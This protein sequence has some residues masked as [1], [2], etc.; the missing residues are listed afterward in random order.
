MPST[1]EEAAH[2]LHSAEVTMSVPEH[3]PRCIPFLTE[4]DL[5][6]RMVACTMVME[7]RSLMDA[8]ETPS[9]WWSP[10]A[11]SCVWLSPGGVFTSQGGV[12][13]SQ[14]PGFVVRKDRK[15]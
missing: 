10:E 13:C 4:G 6:R 7:R 11:S 9:P 8:R 15:G 5:G 3:P 2:H 12:D 1:A 14:L